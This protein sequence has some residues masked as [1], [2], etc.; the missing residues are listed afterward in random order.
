[1]EG[2]LPERYPFS[3]HKNTLP[4]WEPA[5]TPQAQGTQALSVLSIH[6][7]NYA[8]II[9]DADHI[10]KRSHQSVDKF[11]PL[12]RQDFDGCTKTGDIHKKYGKVNSWNVLEHSSRTFLSHY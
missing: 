11:P 9:S 12:I 7:G 8:G 6:P 1:M 3:L 2:L 4:V 10:E 5:T